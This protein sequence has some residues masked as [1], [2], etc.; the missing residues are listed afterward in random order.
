MSL[1]FADHHHALLLHFPVRAGM[2][3]AFCLGAVFATGLTLARDRLR[4]LPF[5]MAPTLVALSRPKV[6]IRQ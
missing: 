3:V 1:W 6:R 2:L 5:F 4:Q